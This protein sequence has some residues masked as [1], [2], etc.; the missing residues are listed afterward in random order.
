MNKQE[1]IDEVLT[2]GVERVYPSKEKLAKKM[3]K[4]CLRVYQGFDPSMP[5][6]HLG[7]LVGVLKLRQFQEL[8]HEVIFLIGDFTGMI[9]DP[10]DKS[11]ARQRLSR[12]EVLANCKSW[13]KQLEPILKFTG[14]NKVKMK[15]NSKWLDKISF[16]EMIEIGANF[17]VQQMIQRD[18]FQKRLEKEKPIYLHEFFYPVAQALDSVKMAIDLEIGGTDQT[19]NMLAGRDLAKNMLGKEKLVLTTKLL[20]DKEGRK[21]GKTTGNAVFLNMEPAKMYGA[22]MS[23]PDEVIIDAFKLL[24]LMPEEEI[25]KTAG[26]IEKGANPMTAKKRLAFEIVKLVKGEKEAQK[27]EKEFERVF[28]KEKVPE[29][30][31]EVKIE[32]KEMSAAESLVKTG[33]CSSRSEAKRMVEQGAVKIDGERIKKWTD[34]VKPKE[35]MVVQ[36]GKRKFVKVIYDL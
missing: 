11:S 33:L 23:F 36:V 22:V 20:V 27:A 2:R 25:E 7:N 10:T 17:T 14:K 28:E 32:K 4:E 19:F 3:E 34:K 8:G 24:T 29:K 6:L 18:F 30:I 31:K 15:F 1:K 16:K 12:E 13:K 5:S 9:G 35:G 21:V 26:E